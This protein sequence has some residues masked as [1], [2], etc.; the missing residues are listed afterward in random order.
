MRLSPVKVKFVSCAI[1]FLTEF[2][3]YVRLVRE[4]SMFE[5]SM[6]FQIRE[7]ILYFNHLYQ[8]PRVK[9]SCSTAAKKC[10]QEYT[11]IFKQ[12]MK[13]QHK[14]YSKIVFFTISHLAEKRHCHSGCHLSSLF[15]WQSL[16]PRS[17]LQ[18]LFSRQNL[19]S[20]FK[21]GKK[22]IDY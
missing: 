20:K 1:I 5:I 2:L 22:S 10:T 3:Y 16:S 13:L 15:I 19:V 8:K 11:L 17:H 14:M 7:S 9:N 12:D 21:V 18:L 4:F 6:I